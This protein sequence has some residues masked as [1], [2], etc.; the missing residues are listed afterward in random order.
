MKNLNRIF[1]RNRR[2]HMY[3]KCVSSSY[4]IDLES[5]IILE[6]LYILFYLAIERAAE[7]DMKYRIYEG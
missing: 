2:V 6:D 4:I 7:F 3:S 5:D 1:Y